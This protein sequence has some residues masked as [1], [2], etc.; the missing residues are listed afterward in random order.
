MVS[1]P[2]ESVCSESFVQASAPLDGGPPE[3]DDEAVDPP[4]AETTRAS[5]V[6][7]TARNVRMRGSPPV[8]VPDGGGAPAEERT[9]LAARPGAMRQDASAS[10]TPGRPAPNRS[11]ARHAANAA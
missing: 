3:E 9:T 10:A 5:P 7:A 4:Q 8:R 1:L 6:A 11:Q 2:D